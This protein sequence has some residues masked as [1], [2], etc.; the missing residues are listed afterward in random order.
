MALPTEDELQALYPLPV[1]PY[2]FEDGPPAVPPADP[3]NPDDPATMRARE[4]RA[5]YATL[6]ARNLREREVWLLKFRNLCKLPSEAYA[7]GTLLEIARSARASLAAE[8]IDLTPRP[9]EATSSYVNP[10]GLT[11]TV[12]AVPPFETAL[13]LWCRS[14]WD[15]GI[16]L[17][18]IGYP[19]TEL[20]SQE[21][22]IQ[23]VKSRG[24]DMSATD[25]AAKSAL[26][27]PRGREAGVIGSARAITTSGAMRV[28]AP[29]IRRSLVQVDL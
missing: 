25:M 9:G 3:D 10:A 6:V 28:L 18:R 19:Q 26:A 4:A 23:R 24:E 2:D 13:A 20:E 16:D 22:T 27:S 12:R 21:A 7:Y 17:P 15:S 5:R 29:F 1:G 14:V 8:L 11:T